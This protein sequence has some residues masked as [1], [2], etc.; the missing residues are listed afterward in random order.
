MI[1]LMGVNAAA[2]GV[3]VNSLP[4]LPSAPEGL[5]VAFVLRRLLQAASLDEAADLALSL[6]HAT[7]QHYLIAAPGRVRSFEASA[8][9]VVEYPPPAPDR[10]LHTNHPLAWPGGEDDAAYRENSQA[11][12]DA[13]AARLAGGPASFEALAAALSSCDDPRHP[14][15][16]S[17]GPS[18]LAPFTAGSM[19]SALAPGGVTAW[20]SPGPP[21]EAGYR[22]VTVPSGLDG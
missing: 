7:N 6:P 20:I 9:G 18:P 3:C 5:P 13:L 2:I 15:C 4:Q 19:I 11:R 21:R 16:R 12:L 22:K 10:V 14:I 17:A 1:G 8:Q